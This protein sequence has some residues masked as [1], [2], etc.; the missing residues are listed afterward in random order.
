MSNQIG[1]G[2]DYQY[3]SDFCGSD[4]SNL[5]SNFRQHITHISIVNIPSCEE[6]RFFRNNISK[7]IPI[8]HHLSGIAPCD[9]DGPNL[10]KLKHQI[11]IS[12]ILSARWCLEDIGIWSLGPYDIPYFIPPIFDQRVAELVAQRIHSITKIVDRPFLMEIPACSF[13]V[14]EMSLGDFFH[15]LVKETHCRVVLDVSHVFSYALAKDCHPLTVLESLPLDSVSEIHIAG[16]RINKRNSKRYID[17]HSDNILDEVISIF[18][19]AIKDCDQLRAIT[20]EIGAMSTPELVDTEF[21]KL[22]S[23]VNQ[24]SFEAKL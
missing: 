8:I 5:C 2:I 24:T 16:G 11:E 3:K 13:V 12:K 14:G 6:A 9:P 18:T 21:K 4:I 7:E 15:H 20:Y 22:N 17:T 23:I 10:E 19:Q 1:L